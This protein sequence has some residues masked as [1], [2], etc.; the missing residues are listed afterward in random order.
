MSSRADSLPL[1]VVAGHICLDIFPD[2]SRWSLRSAADFFA[3]GTLK[4]CGPAEIS[5]GGAVSNTGLNLVKL[6]IPAALMGKVGRDPFGQ[7]V[8]ALLRERFGVREGLLEYPRGVTSY[9]VVLSA[10]GFDRMFLHCPAA[11]DTFCAADVDYE[12]I[13]RAALF[14]FGYP[15]L[16][17]RM[18]EN[19]GAELVELFRRARAAG[20]T[21]ALDMSLPDPASP[22][23]R[24]PWRALLA[25]VLP[26]VDL[27]LPSF[28][29]TLF[30]LAPERFQAWRRAGVDMVEAVSGDELHG[31]SETLL[32]FGAG[33]VGIKTG[34][35]GWYVRS[36]GAERMAAFGR[37]RPGEAASFVRRE[38]WTPALRVETFAGATGA[39]DASIAGFLAAFLRGRSLDD[40]VARAV[41]AGALNVTR[42][43]ALSGIRDWDD[44]EARLAA[45]WP[46]LPLEVAGRGWRRDPAAAQRWLGPADEA[47]R[48]SQRRG[49]AQS[50]PTACR[51]KKKTA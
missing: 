48:A 41:A 10:P 40:C 28:E 33:V 49:G 32:G 29:E 4:E 44:L 46:A 36:G 19:E 21:T 26:N 3:P 20:A 34:R 8:R 51:T 38:F 5:T 45:G 37:A 31:L 42:P 2:L 7:L 22:S 6:G 13:G 25:R 27:F 30:M 17:R 18:Y 1:A 47:R 39:G 16:M 12:L 24:A 35:R 11:N 14:H 15:P 43:D 23:G 9:T 50:G